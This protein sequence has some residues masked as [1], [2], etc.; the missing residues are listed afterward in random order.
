[1]SY[2]ESLERFSAGEPLAVH[3]D[4][5]ERELS[6][7]WQKAGQTTGD[8][9]PVTRACLWNVVY[10][11]EERPG[12]EGAEA[13]PALER[14]VAALPARLANRS[15]VLRTRPP[16]LGQPSLSSYISANC[17][18][19][20]AGGKQVCSEEI[21]FVADDN[22]LDHLPGLVRA[23][24]VPGV[25]VAVVFA[26]LPSADSPVQADLVNL[27]DR[28]ITFMDWSER[29]GDLGATRTL[30]DSRPLFGMD[31]GWIMQTGLR[32]EI[33]HRFEPP[34]GLDHRE[35]RAIRVEHPSERRGTAKMLAGW[36]VASLGATK[37]SAT[38][39][40]WQASL[41]G[42]RMLNLELKAAAQLSVIFTPSSG[43]STP[44]SV[45]SDTRTLDEP[46]AQALSGRRQ[47]RF[48]ETA[49]DLGAQL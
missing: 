25:P 39:Y 43:P 46:L 6:R 26:G 17:V 36:L 3:P 7:L 28:L 31:L 42:G 41:S 34:T 10:V 27:A 22:G 16:A 37:V 18:L 49:L 21:T 15:L 29:S 8:L 35:L 20:K 38:D 2:T 12:H 32:N 9:E 5:I 14:A 1:M 47:D 11:L 30:F 4:A 45:P 19:A 24:L 48:F 23:L 33:A 13:R 44:V 40:G